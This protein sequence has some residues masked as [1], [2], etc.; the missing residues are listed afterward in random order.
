MADQ[1]FIV[2]IATLN[3]EKRFNLNLFESAWC[4]FFDKRLIRMRQVYNQRYI[5]ICQKYHRVPHDIE[6]RLDAI[7]KDCS[8]K[9][10]AVLCHQ[11]NILGPFALVYLQWFCYK[12]DAL[13]YAKSC[14]D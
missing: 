4:T 6:N 7:W 10:A 3:K 1:R 5:E 13:K 12:E 2:E 14:L 11:M 9:I 8:R